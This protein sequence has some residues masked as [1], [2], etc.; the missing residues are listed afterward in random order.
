MASSPLMSCFIAQCII[1]GFAI[2]I[3]ICCIV[4]SC[5]RF[6][7]QTDDRTVKIWFGGNIAF[8]M[9]CAINLVLT[10]SAMS[11][12][13]V[14]KVPVPQAWISW[15]KGYYGIYLILLEMITF[16]KI[17]VS[18]NHIVGVF[19]KYK[20]KIRF[21]IVICFIFGIIIIVSYFIIMIEELWFD[22][23]IFGFGILMISS[24]HI[25]F[26]QWAKKV[27]KI[28]YVFLYT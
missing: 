10:V 4:A 18:S 19:K 2:P 20:N 5:K 6:R 9:S 23:I 28:K 27:K 26:I 1:S 24:P 8:Y 13:I 7:W 17:H 14:Y 15:I 16:L 22:F 12:M 21:C 3:L 11:I 25:I